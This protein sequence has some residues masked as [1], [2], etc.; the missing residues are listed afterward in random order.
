MSC[1]LVGQ[2]MRSCILLTFLWLTSLLPPLLFSVLLLSICNRCLSI[3]S[4]CC[5]RYV[6]IASVIIAA[7]TKVSHTYWWSFIPVLFILQVCS[8]HNSIAQSGGERN[9]KGKLDKFVPCKSFELIRRERAG[10]W[11]LPFYIS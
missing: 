4:M 11:A 7:L 5:S 1:I 9:V 8:V 3:N 2:I 6:Q 10:F